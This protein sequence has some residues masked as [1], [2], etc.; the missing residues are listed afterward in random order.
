MFAQLFKAK[1]AFLKT[2]FTTHVHCPLRMV[3]L[4]SRYTKHKFFPWENFKKSLDLQ[5]I[6]DM[7]RWR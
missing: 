7:A 5:L 3:F 4:E 1:S 2:I 6:S